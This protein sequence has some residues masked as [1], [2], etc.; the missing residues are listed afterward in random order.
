VHISRFY[1]TSAVQTPTT[2]PIASPCI[3]NCC[4]DENDI[5]LGCYRSITEIT[6][7]SKASEDEKAEIIHQCRLREQD[8]RN[9]P[10]K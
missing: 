8:R 6:G 10:V 7:W 5:C 1:K 2:A 9:F 3:R 4:L